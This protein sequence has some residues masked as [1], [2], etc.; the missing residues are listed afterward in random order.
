MS[1]Q[2]LNVANRIDQALQT[3][4]TTL[5]QFKLDLYN[6]IIQILN[7]LQRCI[8][9]GDLSPAAAD[10]LT[11]TQTEL[12]EILGS[13]TNTDNIDIDD[14]NRIIAPL[15]ENQDFLTRTTEAPELQRE[16]ALPAPR[17]KWGFWGGRRRTRKRCR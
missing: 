5:V 10:A 11:I 1:G 9:S 12:E 7:Q 4:D 8:S 14:V 16:Q 6:E 2:V 13:I 3:R 17:R 15:S